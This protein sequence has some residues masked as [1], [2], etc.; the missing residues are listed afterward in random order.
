MKK[1]ISDLLDAYR[2]DSVEL[3]IADNGIGID[4]K[5]IGHIFERFYR[6]DKVR[7]RE[8]GSSGLGLTI[9]KSIVEMLGGNISV[10]SKI[11]TGSAFKIVLY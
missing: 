3:S 11:G 8:K 2:D 7:G 6:C 9:C 4:E 1:R 10:E 5:D